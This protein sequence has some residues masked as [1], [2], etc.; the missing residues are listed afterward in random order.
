MLQQTQVA[1][2]VP[3]FE[4][5][6]ERWPT[7]EALAAAPLGDVLRAWVGLGYN[8]RAVRLWEASRVVARD[9]WPEDLRTL[10]GV[11]PYTA[12]AVGSFAFGR[13]EPA[14]DTNV[15]RVWARLGEPLSARGRAAQLNQAT[16]ELGALVC[17]PRAPRCDACPVAAWCDGPEPA[18]ARRARPERFEGSTR[19]ARGRVVASLAAGE[20]LP[21]DVA[22][23]RLDA[24]LQ[25]LVRDGLVRRTGDGF[26]LG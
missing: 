24:A 13:D 23:E 16:M 3:R 20:G 11:G 22:P 5:W 25:G 21:G 18:P 17:R 15:R 1:R 8:R 12:A 4:A 2:V 10:P 19:W 6:L 26:A 14:M 9:G 7:A